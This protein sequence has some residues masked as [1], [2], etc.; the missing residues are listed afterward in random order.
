MFDWPMSSPQKTTMF[1]F[2]CCAW[3]APARARAAIKT[4]ILLF[5]AASPLRFEREN[6]LP[7]RFHADDNPVLRLG[8]V[9]GFV[10][11]ADVRLAVVGELALRV[12]VM[13][14]EHQAPAFAGGGELQH[15]QVAVGVAESGDR[16]PADGAVDADRLPRS[17]VDEVELRPA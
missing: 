8:F 3:A 11:L 14:E 4:T 2:F 15:L 17:V 7:V 12:V 5:M 6:F 13:H 1:V 10:E 9:P 16:P